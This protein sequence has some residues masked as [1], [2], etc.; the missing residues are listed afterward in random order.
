MTSGRCS[1]SLSVFAGGFSLEAVGAICLDGDESALELVQQLVAS[2]LVV[3][4]DLQGATRYRLLDTI[5]G[6]RGR[7]TRGGRRGR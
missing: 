6:V 7:T 5:R 3:A 2:S 1:D 4:E